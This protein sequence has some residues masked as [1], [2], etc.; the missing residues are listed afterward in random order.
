MTRL[1]SF[2][3]HSSCRRLVFRSDRLLFAVVNLAFL[4]LPTVYEIKEADAIKYENEIVDRNCYNFGKFYF[5]RRKHTRREKERIYLAPI[6]LCAANK[7]KNLRQD[8]ICTLHEG[9]GDALLQSD[10][11]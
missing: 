11:K 7:L 6:L 8:L 1:A 5:Q 3:P 9:S 10:K 2:L 4:S